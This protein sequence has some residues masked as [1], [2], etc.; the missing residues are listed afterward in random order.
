MKLLFAPVWIIRAL[1]A[2]GLPQAAL[3]NAPKLLSILSAE[4]VKVYCRLNNKIAEFLPAALVKSFHAT[5]VHGMIP[6][7]SYDKLSDIEMLERSVSGA[8][9]KASLEDARK[10]ILKA[11]ILDD[12]TLLVYQTG[13]VGETDWLPFYEGILQGLNGFCKFED[14]VK[15][16]LTQEFLKLAH[17]GMAA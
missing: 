5:D 14:F 3:L 4:D 7:D 1:E 11:T 17:K 15:E 10:Y 12:T 9:S 16:P 2:A 8:L 13:V 6:N